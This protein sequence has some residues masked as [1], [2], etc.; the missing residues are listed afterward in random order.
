MNTQL[1][2]AFEGAY[3]LPLF[4]QNILGSALY[5]YDGD[6]KEISTH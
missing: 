2:Q 5:F 1:Q 4:E 3:K 6:Y